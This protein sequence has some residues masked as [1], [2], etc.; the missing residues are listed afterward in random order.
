MAI[1]SRRVESYLIERRLAE[2]LRTAPK[3]ARPR[4]AREVYA[5]LY[6]LVPWHPDLTRTRQERESSTAALE[7]TYGRWLDSVRTVLEIGAG[8]CELVRR[9]GPKHAATLFVVMDVTR[10]PLAAVADPLPRNSSFVQAG[11]AAIPVRTAAFDF[12]YCSQVL[13][14]FHPDDVREYLSEVVRVLKPGGWLGLDTPNRLSGPHDVSRGFTPEATGLHLKEWTYHE[15]RSMLLSTGFDRVFTRAL[16]G[17]ISRL[18]HLGSPGPLVDAR[19]KSG[20]ERVISL[21]RPQSMRRVM[22]RLAGVDGIF[23]YARRGRT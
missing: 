7:H 21:A 3:D 23:L 9:V 1:A 10:E 18:L 17:R 6:R 13:E 12:V 22:A 15:L 8:S 20:L 16:P 11:A 2:R 19:V 4:V 14:H 5:D